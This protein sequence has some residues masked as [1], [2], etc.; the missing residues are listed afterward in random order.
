MVSK[1]LL[2][3]S[4]FSA[5]GLGFNENIAFELMSDFCKL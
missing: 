2:Q 4:V 3:P 5:N 1:P